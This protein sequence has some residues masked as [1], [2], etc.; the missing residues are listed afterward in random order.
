[1]TNEIITSVSV[2]AGGSGY[3]P[4]GTFSVP[5]GSGG[6]VYY[7]S[8]AGV[9]NGVSVQ[10]GGSGYISPTPISVQI[11]PQQLSGLTYYWDIPVAAGY[12]RFAVTSPL[13]GGSVA[14][15]FTINAAF[16]TSAVSFNN[17]QYLRLSITLAS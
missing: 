3:A 4:T 6:I 11:T 10:A 15:D 12:I 2:Q 14:F 17:L 13:G 16:T 7:T 9:I 8:S 1:V 5:G